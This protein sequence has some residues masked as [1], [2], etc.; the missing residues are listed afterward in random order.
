M[1]GWT[2]ALHKFC[3][4]TEVAN[5]LIATGVRANKNVVKQRQ[6]AVFKIVRD[7]LFNISF[8]FY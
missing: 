7:F 3:A 2:T 8:Y 5:V 6:S 1:I 4:L